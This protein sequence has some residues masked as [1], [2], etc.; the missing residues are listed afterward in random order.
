MRRDCFREKC[1]LG[2]CF[3]KYG[4]VMKILRKGAMKKVDKDQKGKINDS[5][6]EKIG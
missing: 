3:K 4:I 5:S 1:K 6:L 2:E